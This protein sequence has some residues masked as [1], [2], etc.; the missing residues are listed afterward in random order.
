MT[1]VVRST[2]YGLDRRQRR[3]GFVAALDH[4]IDDAKLPGLIGSHEVIAI[5]RLV[6]YFIA[7]LGMLNINLI[8]PP[9]HL[10]DVLGMAFDVA[11]LP[12]EATRR[13]VHHDA[14]IG[15]S[16]THAWGA[17]GEQQR[18]HGGGLAD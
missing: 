2:L 15:Q 8:E 14:R 5:E 16:V 7:F 18:A 1:A 12:G 17:S 6:D 10:D 13:L 9:L 11:C 3:L 4:A